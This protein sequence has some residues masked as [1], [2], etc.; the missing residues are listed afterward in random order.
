MI[1]AEARR[2][3][4]YIAVEV[5]ELA[6]EGAV[7]D[8][9]EL[10]TRWRSSLGQAEAIIDRLPANEVGN[11]VLGARGEVFRGSADEATAALTRGD[12]LFQAGSIRG[13]MPELCGTWRGGP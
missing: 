9:A 8:A 7:P 1:I 3:A 5:A 4:R 6:F 10:S 2:S 13:A 11:V 12:I